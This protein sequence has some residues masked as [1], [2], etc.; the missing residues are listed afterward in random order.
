M[1][2]TFM[3]VIIKARRMRWAGHVARTGEV[4]IFGGKARGKQATRKTKT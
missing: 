4:Y 3:Y 2:D 1:S